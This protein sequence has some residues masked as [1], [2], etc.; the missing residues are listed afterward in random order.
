YA[1]LT[2]M[3]QK[4][5]SLV[6]QR[7]AKDAD[8]VNFT[9][10]LLEKLNLSDANIFLYLIDDTPAFNPIGLDHVLISIVKCHAC[11]FDIEVSL[12][13]GRS[14]EFDASNMVSSWVSKIYV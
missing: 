13:C 1:S 8:R 7:N 4:M 3:V 10:K 14:E 12:H 9:D 2:R 6:K 5:V 11:D